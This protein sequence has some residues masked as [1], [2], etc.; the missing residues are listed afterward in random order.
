HDGEEM[1][2]LD[3]VNRPLKE[4]YL[5]I[6]NGYESVALAGVMGGASTEVEKGTKN[7]LLE[8]AYFNPIIVRKAS[9]ELG[10]RS[11][12][13][14][15]FEKGVDPNRVKEAGLRATE[16]IAELAGGKIV[17]GIAEF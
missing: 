3:H 6:T 10:L 17:S 14:S 8:A 7:I 12:S 5:A 4:D 13:S 2:T 11:D 15:R 16:L 9:R 1:E